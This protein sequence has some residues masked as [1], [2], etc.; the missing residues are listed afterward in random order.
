MPDSLNNIVD[1][2]L[3]SLASDKQLSIHI[4]GICMQPLIWDGAL[5]SVQKQ[6]FYWPGDILVKRDAN[7]QL[8]AHRLI[9]FF[10]REGQLF[11]VSRADNAQKADAPVAGVQ[12]IGRVSGGECARS[13]V[14]VPLRD[15]LRSTRQFTVLLAKRLGHRIASIRP[16][17]PG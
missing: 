2:A 12:I 13:V 5:V 11:Y 14:S 1:T 10:P 4:N 15:R 9:G 6:R 17:K 7:G 16:H 8:I 3:K